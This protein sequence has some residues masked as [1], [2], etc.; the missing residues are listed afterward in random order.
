M[1]DKVREADGDVPEPVLVWDTLSEEWYEAWMA[2]DG[3]TYI[4]MSDLP[5]PEGEQQ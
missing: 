5:R 2:M 4:L 3:E 1:L